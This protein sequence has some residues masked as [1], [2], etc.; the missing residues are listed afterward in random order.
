MNF[1][2]IVEELLKIKG[3]P[4]ES[5]SDMLLLFLTLQLEPTKNWVVLRALQKASANGVWEGRKVP[6]K[7]LFEKKTPQIG[8]QNCSTKRGV[9][10]FALNSRELVKAERSFQEKSV[11]ANDP[12]KWKK[13]KGA[14]SLH[15]L[16][17]GIVLPPWSLVG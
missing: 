2:C 3:V 12:I 14:F 9:R 4:E 13:I 16:L 8:A 15:N 11:R 7:S 10:E 1:F 5:G 17:V 6:T